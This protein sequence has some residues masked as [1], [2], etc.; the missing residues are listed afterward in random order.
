MIDFFC[1]A[2]FHFSAP[3]YIMAERDAAEYLCS[4]SPVY[5]QMANNKN[6]FSLGRSLPV[7]QQGLRWLVRI[8][9]LQDLTLG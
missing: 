1:I 3:S 9:S 2:C 6:L 4:Y 8:E 7:L 5:Q